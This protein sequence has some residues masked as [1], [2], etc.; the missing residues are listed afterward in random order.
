MLTLTETSQIAQT[1]RRILATRII[2]PAQEYA[3]NQAL[4]QQDLAATDAAL[5]E[6][7]LQGLVNGKIVVLS[8]L[9]RSQ[10]LSQSRSA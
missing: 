10:S 3:I 7:L 9:G 8:E 2:T 1:A 6:K 5:L 4:W